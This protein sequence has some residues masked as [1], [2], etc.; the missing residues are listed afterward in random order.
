MNKS[1]KLIEKAQEEETRDY[2]FKIYL[3]SYPGMNK[4]NFKTFNEFWDEIRPQKIEIDARST[5][6]I[7]K[8]ILETEKSF[9]KRGEENGIV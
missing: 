2:A 7:M 6:D 5:E 3:A 1:I 8:E 4:D 9:G